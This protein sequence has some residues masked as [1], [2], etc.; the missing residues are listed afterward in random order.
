MFQT[1]GKVGGTGRGLEDPSPR[2]SSGEFPPLPVNY[3]GLL[4]WEYLLPKLTLQTHILT[5]EK[6]PN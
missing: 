6:Q 4:S 3:L 1:G 5:T 2:S